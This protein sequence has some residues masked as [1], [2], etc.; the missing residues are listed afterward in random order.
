VSPDGAR[1]I[2][3]HLAADTVDEIALG[4]QPKLTS[5]VID[6]TIPRPPAQVNPM[7]VR[8]AITAAFIGNGIAVIPHQLDMTDQSGGQKEPPRSTYGGGFA[9]PITTRVDLVGPEKSSTAAL[10]L[11]QQARGLAWDAPRDRLYLTGYG[12]DNL[13]VLD[14]V[15]Q[16]SPA[17]ALGP[18]PIQVAGGCGPSAIAVSDDGVA[19]AWCELARKVA[20]VTPRPTAGVDLAYSD[21]VAPS[22]LDAAAQRGRALF[23]AGGNTAL[24]TGGALACSSCHPDGRDDG[25]TWR[26]EAHS[27]QTPLLAGRVD[28][29]APYKWDGRDATLSDSLIHTVQ[30][31]GGSGINTDQAADL[32][33]YIVSL[34]RPRVPAPADGAA[35]AR[36]KSLFEGDAKCSSCHEG[37]KLTDGKLHDLA[38]DLDHVDTPSLIAVSLSAPYYHDGSAPTLRDVL[39]GKG[40]VTGMGK[41]SGL[42]SAQVDDLV[43]Y[44]G[45][46]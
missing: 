7:F 17:L 15:S 31:L 44:L 24:S 46:L 12:T 20:F 3:T 16:A 36:G 25:L 21:E 5:R 13:V 27:L 40:T 29:T 1:A 33:A 10:M 39:T 8:G 23:R 28:G 18:V 9:P 38:T 32:Q 37:A 11:L 2:V 30:R 43:A 6:A 35:V 14:R 4:K 22:R 19:M 42:S 34:P 26:I 45:T 41:L